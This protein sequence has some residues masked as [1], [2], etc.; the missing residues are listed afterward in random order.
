MK[1]MM[2]AGA[3]YQRVP[4]IARGRA[5]RTWARGFFA[6]IALAAMI[7]GV[8]TA[9]ATGGKLVQEAIKFV[10]LA[11]AQGLLWDQTKSLAKSN[12]PSMTPA[13]LEAAMA[14]GHRV[15]NQA[16]TDPNP[17]EQDCM[18]DLYAAVNPKC[19]GA[20]AY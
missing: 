9:D 3:V 6:A 19:K 5:M 2:N 15:Y 16:R 14:E 4:A 18:W 13:D 7:G 12:F 10:A 17:S 8:N 11:F 20:L 1:R